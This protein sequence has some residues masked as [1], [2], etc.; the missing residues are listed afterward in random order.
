LPN[1]AQYVDPAAPGLQEVEGTLVDGIA[2][3]HW[4][5]PLP[6][7]R[8]VIYRDGVRQK[9]LAGDAVAFQDLTPITGNSAKYSLVGDIDGVVSLRA[10]LPMA[11]PQCEPPASPGTPDRGHSDL[12]LYGKHP[13]YGSGG[14]GEV[15][16]PIQTSHVDSEYHA[17]TLDNGVL[18][19]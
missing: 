12:I 8:I 16:P 3:L 13:V 7:N 2:E 17:F 11:V 15:S 18:K 5:N 6:F 10:N 14:G 9:V 4:R 1:A 19:F